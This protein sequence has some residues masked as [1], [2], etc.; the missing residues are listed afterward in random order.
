[1]EFVGQESDAERAIEQIR[2]LRPDVVIVDTSNVVCDASAVV[3]R[4]LQERIGDKVVRLNLHDNKICIFHEEQRSIRGV[5][6]LLSAIETN[7]HAQMNQ[8]GESQVSTGA[9]LG[10]R[11]NY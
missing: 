6:D 1:M 2:T 8:K 10:E 11:D 3:M 7:G 5:E 4:I 9:E